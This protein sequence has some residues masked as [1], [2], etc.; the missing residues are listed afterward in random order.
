MH[1]IARRDLISELIYWRRILKLT[2][3]EE[4][5]SSTDQMHVCVLAL[6]NNS[7][8]LNRK[9]SF[10]NTFGFGWKFSNKPPDTAKVIFNYFFSN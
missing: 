4:I 5:S 10:K 8:K 9:Q 6:R 2:R 3:R 7:S 1:I